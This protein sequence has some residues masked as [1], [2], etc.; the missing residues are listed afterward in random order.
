MTQRQT[1][2]TKYLTDKMPHK[3][4]KMAKCIMR[5]N[6]FNLQNDL[7]LLNKNTISQKAVLFRFFDDFSMICSNLN[8]R[9]RENYF[10]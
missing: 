5:K 9:E 8:L 2:R 6:Y 4:F 7:H 10:H 1:T 3:Q